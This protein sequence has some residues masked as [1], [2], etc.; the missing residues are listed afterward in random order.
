MSGNDKIVPSLLSPEKAE[1][2]YGSANKSPA[3]NSGQAPS[4]PT[5]PLIYEINTRSWLKDWEN[6]APRATPFLLQD[7]PERQFKEWQAQGFTHIWLMGVW[8]IGPK[9]RKQAESQWKGEARQTRREICG[10][11]FSIA[12]WEVCESIGGRAGLALFRERLHAYGLALIVDFVPNHLGIDHPWIQERPGLFVRS[13]VRQEG[14]FRP[15]REKNGEAP[16]WF[17]QGKDPFFP[18]WND[19]VQ[20]DYRNVPS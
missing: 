11:P 6:Q 14:T 17:A 8:K 1:R 7:V 12:A 16:A 18:P 4:S 10:S 3:G 15:A 5:F 20:L 9:A 2:A 13:A 19:T